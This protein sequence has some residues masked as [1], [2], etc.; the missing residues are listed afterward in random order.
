MRRQPAFWGFAWL[1]AL[2]SFMIAAAFAATND[3][4]PA[5]IWLAHQLQGVDSAAFAHI[6]DWTADLADLPLIAIVWPSA[7]LALLLLAGRGPALLLI[8]STGGR[9]VNSGI[10]EVIERPRP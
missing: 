8:L 6:L 7:A 2:I 5:D 3:T 4:F 1:A 10:K 9:L